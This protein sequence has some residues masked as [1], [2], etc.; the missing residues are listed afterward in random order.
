VS[1]YGRAGLVFVEVVEYLVDGLFVVVFDVLE[2][3][4]GAGVTMLDDFYLLSMGIFSKMCY[5]RSL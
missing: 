3:L 5:F 1:R 2:S 4:S